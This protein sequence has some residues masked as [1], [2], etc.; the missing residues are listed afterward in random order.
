MLVAEVEP[1]HDEVEGERRVDLAQAEQVLVE[2]PAPLDIRDDDG[3][4][5]DLGD[6][7]RMA[8]GVDSSRLERKNPGRACLPG[9]CLSC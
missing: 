9:P 2:P 3:A 8:H 7:Q 4:M 5:I 1:N 6:L